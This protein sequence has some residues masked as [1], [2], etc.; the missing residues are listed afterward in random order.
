MR[1]FYLYA[2]SRHAATRRLTASSICEY[3]T[4]FTLLGHD[5]HL[6]HILQYVKETQLFDSR[7]NSREISSSGSRQT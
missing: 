4:K 1:F 2:C 3:Y 5:S 7:M 6:L